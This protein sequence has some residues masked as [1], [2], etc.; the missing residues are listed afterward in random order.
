MTFPKSP[1]QTDDLVNTEGRM[2]ARE[3]RPR[4][5]PTD[6]DLFDVSLDHRGWISAMLPLALL[7][8]SGAGILG[9]TYWLLVNGW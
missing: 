7:M 9:A 6:S 2:I 3:E 1:E 5:D 8:A 4:M